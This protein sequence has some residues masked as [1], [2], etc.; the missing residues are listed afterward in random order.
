MSETRPAGVRGLLH[1]LTHLGV[2]PALPRQ[3]TK[4]IVLT[5]GYALFGLGIYLYALAASPWTDIRY[6]VRLALACGAVAAVT[7]LAMNARGRHGLAAAILQ[8]AMIAVFFYVGICEP[9]ATEHIGIMFTTAVVGFFLF[10]HRMRAFSALF[11]LVSIVAA[12][13]MRVILEQHPS[14]PQLPE[15]DTYAIG[16]GNVILGMA[17][18]IF[19]SHRAA[20]EIARVEDELVAERKKT[21]TLLKREVAHQVAERSRELGS[22]LAHGSGSLSP[23]L[24]PTRFGS[25]Y[26]VLRPLGEGGMG[27]VVEVERTTDGAKLALKVMTGAVS[28]EQAARFA[29]EAEIGARVHHENLVSIVDVGMAEGG[30]PYLVMELAAGGSLEGQ[31]ARFGDVPW[32]LAILRQMA[33]GL[34]AL[35]EAGVVHRDL[36]PAN[37]LLDGAGHAK[38]SDFGIARMGAIPMGAVDPEAA[39][40]APARGSALTGTGAWIGTPLYMAPEAARGGREA[41]PSLDVFAFGLVAYELLTGTLPFTTPPV[42][43]A[44]VGQSLPS[45]PRLDVAG[46]D[47]R[48]CEVL[49]ACLAATPSA[50]PTAKSMLEALRG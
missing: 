9:L 21:E 17:T 43:L 4:H 19:F 27:A 38:L 7:T 26:K 25:R 1:R 2:D 6:D 41:A 13:A 40:A 22:A 29:R 15:F 24:S 16:V 36:K 35:H 39:T 10:P 46:L 42:L 18:L 48:A 33:A 37:V 45:V 23:S 31:R 44:L 47:A 3:E 28:R 12:A 50:R 11:A 20:S 32:A 49:I 14:P 34:V 5:N 8:M 30:A